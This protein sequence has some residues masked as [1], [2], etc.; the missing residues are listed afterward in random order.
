MK[1]EKNRE[2]L[3][4]KFEILKQELKIR[5]FSQNT[6][7]AYIYH[8]QRF[9]NFCNKSPREVNNK[10]IKNYIESLIDKKLASASVRLVFNALKFYYTWILRRK[11][12]NDLILPKREQKIPVFLTKKEVSDLLNVIKN[13][14][15]H[16]LIE[17]IYASGLRVSE[18]VRFKVENIFIDEAIAIVKQGKGKKDRKVILSE[19]FVEDLR[20]YLRRKKEGY[21]FEGRNGHLTERSVQEIISKAAKKA[22]INKNV[23]P[24]SLRHSF[25]TH[26]IESGTNTSTLQKLLGHSSLRT[27]Q[28]YVHLSDKDIKSIESPLD[29]L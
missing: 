7:D 2:I 14:K 27:T 17:F 26:L 19:K 9:L 15:H 12:F 24:H 11:L 22:R 10:D 5:G 1:N 13:P 4:N 6:L 20:N 28:M 18:V 16:L 25:A 8:N 3:K 21:L 23:H 29:S